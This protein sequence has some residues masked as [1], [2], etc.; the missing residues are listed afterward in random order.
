[1]DD[2]KTIKSKMVENIDKNSELQEI[3]DDINKKINTKSIEE[4][5]KKEY[6]NQPRDE[7]GNVYTNEPNK[8]HHSLKHNTKKAARAAGIK[9][10][11][12]MTGREF[13]NKD[14]F[15]EIPDSTVRIMAQKI[16][17]GIPRRIA[18]RACGVVENLAE[19]WIDK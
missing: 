1:M 16:K 6:V 18:A 13:L 3:M 4:K 19:F 9:E 14:K 2:F 8:R 12:D 7:N 5:K 11:W 17:D 15:E 10:G